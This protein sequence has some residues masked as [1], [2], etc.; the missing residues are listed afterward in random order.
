[1]LLQEIPNKDMSEEDSRSKRICDRLLFDSERAAELE[2]YTP[3]IHSI[4]F[5]EHF[6]RFWRDQALLLLQF[7]GIDPNSRLTLAG[8]KS[9]PETLLAYKKKLNETPWKTLL[10]KCHFKYSNVKKT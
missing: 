8:I 2:G 9:R 5:L 6:A 3:G 4:Y 10:E 1:V 7:V